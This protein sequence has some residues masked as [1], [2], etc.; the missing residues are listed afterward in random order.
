MAAQAGPGRSQC[1]SAEMVVATLL[2]QPCDVFLSHR[3]PD[4]KRH[5]VSHLVQ[6]LERASLNVFVDYTM[7]K[8]VESWKTILA[9]LRGARRIVILLSPR[10]EESCWCLEEVRAAAQRLDAVL[11]IFLNR[12]PGQCNTSELQRAE[13]ELR[14]EEPGAPA[15]VVERWRMAV[16]SLGSVSGWP[17]SSRTDYEAEL[18]DDVLAELLRVLRPLN[19]LSDDS[20][21]GLDQL[22]PRL[23]QILKSNK[24]LGLWGMG[25]VGKTTI[26]SELLNALQPEF[27][28]AV[29]FLENVRDQAKHC[30]GLVK[31][32][33]QLLTS[34]IRK[35]ME[36]SGERHGKLLLA[37]HLQRCRALI[38][39]DDLVA[40]CGGLP[41]TLKVLGSH[42][43]AFGHKQDVWEDALKRLQ[44]AEELQGRDEPLFSRLRI[45]YDLLE[46]PEQRMFL[47]SACF[48]L[49]RRADT[50]K[51][52]WLRSDFG[53]STGL[54][55]LEKCCLLHVSAV[56]GR[57]SM[58]DQLR[59]LAWAIVSEGANVSPCERTWLRGDDAAN[60][61][62][63]SQSQELVGLPEDIQVLTKLKELDVSECTALNALPRSL[64]ALTGLES[65]RLH[66]CSSLSAL[67]DTIGALLGLKELNLRGCCALVAMPGPLGAL[68]GLQRL[69]L[70]SCHSL[71]TL[72]DSVGN[73]ADLVWLNLEDC[74]LLAELPES[75]SALTGLRRFDL[76][77]CRTLPAL[78]EAIGALTSLQALPDSLG[79]LTGL[80]RL[81]LDN[82]RKLSA[83]PTSL[84][85]LTDLQRL[86]LEG[87]RAL[88]ELP[89]TLGLLTRLE[90]LRLDGC[91]SLTGLPESLG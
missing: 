47:D 85:Y 11:P 59:D 82:C 66:G 46:K 21:V 54:Y 19:H 69:D 30:G 57:L 5:L 84:G 64:G 78:P 83:L 49:G 6:R 23:M 42:L 13:V 24:V 25:G 10:F 16:E 40:A 86:R 74:W 72:P 79:E 71:A 60:L 22:V 48:F 77:N 9:K 2:E 90:E 76:R 18:V 51:R 28:D 4:S 89:Q 41:L 39:I 65:F 29:C 88:V 8:G 1:A 52:A 81:C 3:G 68:T 56:S 35:P 91:K 87:C 17:Q 53:S 63:E 12:A 34:L 7:P 58:H 55:T 31:L 75:L 43:S 20:L 38:I 15:N 73:L 27:S 67:P 36:V 33:G 61:L 50:A 44:D 32:Q 14:K 26:A 62:H 45:S 37:T 70:H 80:R